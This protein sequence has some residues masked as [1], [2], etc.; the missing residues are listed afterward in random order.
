MMQKDPHVYLLTESAFT[1][2]QH[3]AINQSV[4]IS[5]ESGA[6]KTET[7][8]FVLNYLCSVTSNISTWVQHQII[9]ANTILE[10]FGKKF[11]LCGSL[12]TPSSKVIILNVGNAKTIR[13]DN[14]SR[15]GKFMQVCFD[16]HTKISGCI[17]QDYLLELS[18][19][20][21]QR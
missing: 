11:T 17:I 4:V 12:G 10:A 1:S 6:G 14:S 3:K 20:T 16:P 2:L 8:K 19:I 18:R 21:V 13:N 9:E 15:F 5:G 7:A